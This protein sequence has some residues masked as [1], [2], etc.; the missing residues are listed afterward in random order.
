MHTDIKSLRD[1]GDALFSKRTSLLSLWQNIAEEFYVERADFTAGR[2]LGSEFGDHLTTSY[3]TIARRDLANTFSSMLRP[4]DKQWFFLRP[5]QEWRENDATLKWMEW[6]TGL[7]RRAMYDSAANFV[8]ATKEGDNDFAAFGQ[9][10]LSVELNRRKQALLYRTWHL[11]DVA[12]CEGAEGKVEIVHRNWKPEARILAQLFKNIH[13][14]VTKCLE[15]EPYKEINCR[16]I[17]IPTEE[18]QSGDIKKKHKTQFVSI[19]IDL[20]NNKTMEEIGINN[21]CYVIP[22]WQTVAGSQYAYSP[23]TVAALS[24]A[25]LIQAMTLTLLEA[26]Q[27]AADPP[28]IAVQEAIRSDVSVY[29]GGITWVDAEYDERL[30]EVLRPI[31]QDRNGIPLGIEMQRDI[32]EQIAE[33]FFLNKIGL[34]PV[35]GDMTAFEVG[36]RVS[37]YVRNALPLFEPMEVEYNGGLCELT[38]DILMGA[39]AFGPVDSIPDELRGGEMRFR[40]ESPLAAAQEHQKSQKFLETK[41]MLL[42]A[43]QLDQSAPAILDVK[44]A[45]RDVLSGGVSQAKWLRTDDELE[46][47]AQE[48][49][50]KDAMQQMMGTL[51]QGG[52]AAEQIGN[53]G[54]ALQEGLGGVM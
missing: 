21:K 36:Q 20:D 10:V 47:I 6:A 35:K 49:A 24:D 13:E 1:H 7:Q 31:T 8:R 42:E 43:A 11:R 41:A 51:T 4:T 12:W 5:V 18:Y 28:M 2:T 33:A 15:K 39:G 16:H 32:R 9:C 30:G 27:K 25:R 38:F 40:F 3:P 14:S 44:V 54:K 29:A 48:Q 17:I 46:A 45:L 19:H 22:R 34:P 53:A 26:G 52:M 50:Q 23:A 37:E